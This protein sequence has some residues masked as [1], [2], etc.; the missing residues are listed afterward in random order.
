MDL[1]FETEGEDIKDIYNCS[2]FKPYDEIENL[3]TNEGI[4]INEDDKVTFNKTPDYL[5]KVSLA[6]AAYS[7]IITI[8]PRQLNFKEL[9]Y[10]LDKH[11]LLNSGIGN[12]TVFES[13]MKWSPFSSLYTDLQEIRY[14][15]RDHLEEMIKAN[16]ITDRIETEQDLIDWL[17]K[18]EVIYEKA[19]IHLKCLFVKEDEYF[20]LLNNLN[21]ILFHGEAFIETFSFIE[22]YHKHYDELFDKYGTYTKKEE[23]EV[24]HNPDSKVEYRQVFSLRFHLA[25]RKAMEENG[26]NIPL[27]LNQESNQS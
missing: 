7:E 1:I 16:S 3:R 2:E 5:A 8:P 9:S 12:Y 6:E 13:R 27:Y 26:I 25:R 24:I 23:K 19:S 4:Y 11:S 14:Y 15:I 20:K 10:W 21:P 18:Y 22:Y 17:F